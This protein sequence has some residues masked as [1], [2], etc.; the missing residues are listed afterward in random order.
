MFFDVPFCISFSIKCF[1]FC[2]LRKGSPPKSS[3]FCKFCELTN[4]KVWPPDFQLIPNHYY[5]MMVAGDKIGL[6]YIGDVEK[7][8]KNEYYDNTYKFF[9]QYYGMNGKGLSE[10]VGELIEDASDTISNF[11][12]Q[13]FWD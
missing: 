4:S 6:L 10:Q 3:I 1:L 9:Q 7:G 2:L 13:I 8:E 11:F 12:T 5:T